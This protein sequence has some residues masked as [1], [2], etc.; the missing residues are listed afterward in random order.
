METSAIKEKLLQRFNTLIEEGEKIKLSPSIIFSGNILG[1]DGS[2]F[3]AWLTNVENLLDTVLPEKAELRQDIAALQK[4]I[5][6]KSLPRDKIH[7]RAMGLLKG[8]KKDF[9]SGLFDSLHRENFNS[10]SM[11]RS[12][13]CAK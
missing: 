1:V 12:A 8:V 4:D 7:E 13:K 9:E 5:R 10:I 11:E 2:Q 3:F 6:E